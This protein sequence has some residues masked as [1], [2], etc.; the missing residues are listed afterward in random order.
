M[1]DTLAGLPVLRAAGA[2]DRFEE[3]NQR[4]L[5]LNQRCQFAAS[6][7]MQ[8]LDIRLQ[9][10]GAA[11]VSAIAGIALVQHQQGLANPGLVGLS[12]SYALSLT[13]LLSGLVSS[14]TQ[15]EAMLVSVE[16]LEEYCC[17][18]P[19]EPQGQP[20]QG[21]S[22]LAQGSVEF[23]DVVLVYRP[24]LP[25]AL[26]GVT[27]CVQPG[28]KLGIVGRTGSGKS[29][30]LL[31]LFRLLEPSS[32][33]VLL[34]GVDTR[35]LQ[36]AELRS[37]LAIIPQEP[38]LFSGTVREN[39]DPRG[40]HEDEALWQAL[41]QCHLKEV[42]GSMGECWA[43]GAGREQ[44]RPGSAV[45][46]PWLAGGL[47][48]ELG[49]GGR[50]LSLGQRQLLCLARALLTEA[51]I[52]CI[53]EATASVDQKTEQLLQQTIRKRFANKTVLT[54]A[55]RL[56]T[57]L[58]SDRVLVLQAGRVVELDSPSALRSQPHSLFQQLLQSSQ[59]AAHPSP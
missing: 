19:Q 37:Q 20:L 36:L 10:M 16:R 31:V 59:Q 42:I 9:L 4:L 5:E 11:V 35:Q 51:K 28:E 47:D 52:L 53:D 54:I 7:T 1:A 56:S 45:K 58:N 27:F 21:F 38:F 55:H 22:W 48:G 46:L 12:L 14:F 15:T 39:L 17:D 43:L 44:G 24:G 33:R 6:A 32:G 25:H 23:Q 49:E 13:G 41:E 26:D 29:S 30:L 8:W 40:L 50:S 3:E 57:I 2:T 18:L 34:D